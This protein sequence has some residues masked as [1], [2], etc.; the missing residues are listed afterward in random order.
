MLEGHL[1]MRGSAYTG[2]GWRALH[3]SARTELSSEMRAEDLWPMVRDG[4]RG[5]V[6]SLPARIRAE[7]ETRGLVSQV[8]WAVGPTLGGFHARRRPCVDE[9]TWTD[10]QAVQQQFDGLVISEIDKARGELAIL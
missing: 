9:P 10:V 4:L 1:A 2:E 7:A 5:L 3:C 8:M 6:C